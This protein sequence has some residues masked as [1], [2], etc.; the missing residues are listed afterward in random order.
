MQNVTTSDLWRVFNP[1][2]LAGPIF[3]KELRVASRRGRTYLLRFAYI[4]VLSLFVFCSWQAAVGIRAAAA[5]SVVQASRMGS[6][7]LVIVVGITW[8]QFLM[9]QLLAV[10]LLSGAIGDEIRKRSLDALL[11]SPISSL[12]IVLGKLFSQ[13]LQLALLLAVSL[14]LLAVVRAFGGV[15]WN[16]VVSSLCITLT[17]ALVAGSLSLFL[18][19]ADRNTRTVVSSA[20]AWCGV[21]WG[22][23]PLTFVALRYANHTVPST[24]QT[25]LYLIN[26]FHVLAGLSARMMAPGS[27]A[28]FPMLNWPLHCLIMLAIAAVILMF[29][30]RQVRRAALAPVAGGGENG[31]KKTANPT[32]LD[33][34]SSRPLRRVKG[35]PIV[36]REL[37]RPIFPRGRRGLVQMLLL[38]A[39]VGVTTAALVYSVLAMQGGLTALCVVSAVLLAVVF[40]F[41]VTSAAASSITREKESRSL[42]IL[43]T[44]PFEDAKIVKD[45][46]IG[47]LRRNVPLLV[48]VP[49]LGL[50]AYLLA[51]TRPH[52]ADALTAVLWFSL[53]LAGH[54]ALLMG[55]GFCLSTYLKTTAAAVA[56]TFGLFFG[57]KILGSMFLMPIMLIFGPIAEGNPGVAFVAYAGTQAAVCA[58]IGW[59]LGR[60]ACAA[61]RPNCQK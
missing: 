9:S 17:A 47:I 52:L 12:Q 48:P 39:A 30:V 20:I 6:A 29:S 28:A 10:I 2:R 41:N 27:G 44:I 37:K 5:S 54:T 61:L 21:A 38:I 57:F 22:L 31:Q 49:L 1:L 60:V 18:S 26:P 23:V 32:V 42:Q 15:P 45:K 35:S 58:G 24:W 16:Y 46:A 53:S 34:L 3:D 4:G 51:S 11:A 19:I 43:L 8:V 7:G 59:V 36:W 55:L 56:L 50:L 14:P 13:L 25:V 33:R 40:V